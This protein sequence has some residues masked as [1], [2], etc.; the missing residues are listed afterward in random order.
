MLDFWFF[1]V[2]ELPRGWHLGA[3]TCNSW[4]LTWSVF[5]DLCSTAFC[6]LIYWISFLYFL[7]SS[8]YGTQL[9]VESGGMP[10]NVQ[11]TR[12]TGSLCSSNFS[13][14]DFIPPK[15]YAWIPTFWLI[16][17]HNL[18]NLPSPYLMYF[19]SHYQQKPLL[20][21][22]HHLPQ[23]NLV[24]Y[25]QWPV[26][27]QELWTLEQLHSGKCLMENKLPCNAC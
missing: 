19:M 26:C 8:S 22:P 23:K 13:E 17:L 15:T 24:L 7:V 27:L 12:C 3:E 18:Q 2:I 21:S 9:W 10:C 6:W 4:P 14:A 5:N 11:N 1:V 16:H 25:S 20:R